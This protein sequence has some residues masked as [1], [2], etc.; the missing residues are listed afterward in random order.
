MTA[1]DALSQAAPAILQFVIRIHARAQRHLPLD[2]HTGYQAVYTA[3]EDEL[4]ALIADYA[5]TDPSIQA[6]LDQFYISQAT[7]L[8]PPPT[9]EYDLSELANHLEQL[10]A[11]RRQDI[12]ECFPDDGEVPAGLD[13][14]ELLTHLSTVLENAPAVPTDP[15]LTDN[16]RELAAMCLETGATKIYIL[17]DFDCTIKLPDDGHQAR[18]IQT[19]T[20]MLALWSSRETGDHAP[21]EVIPSQHIPSFEQ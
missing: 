15:A 8:Q 3:M 1:H 20:A 6:Q 9:G 7:L 18:P 12:E 5:D 17:R 19:P 14:P 21:I 10:L 2:A 13:D 11:T 4:Q 16:L